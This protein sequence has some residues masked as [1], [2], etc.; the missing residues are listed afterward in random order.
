MSHKRPEA[1]RLAVAWLAVA[2][3][4]QLLP[5]A[6]FRR[7]DSNRD[8]EVD[9]SDPI[10]LLLQLFGGAPGGTCGDASDADDDGKVS[11]T[12]AIRILS[13]LFQEGA[14][15]PPPSE[16]CGDDPTD[17]GL[18]C[19]GPGPCA[20]SP[21]AALSDDFEG[22]ALDPSWTAHNA[23]LVNVTLSG[24]ALELEAPVNS[25]W[26]NDSEGPL[27]FKTVAGDFRVT[28]TVRARRASDPSLPPA[29]NV[30]LG[31][32]M[33]RDPSGDGGGA[34]N[35]VFIVVGNDVN[36][37]SV[38]TKTTLSSVSSYEGPSWP[39]GDAELRVC[40]LGAVVRLYKRL[41][42]AAEWTL[43]ATFT[44]PD[45]PGALQAGPF[46]YAAQGGPDLIVSFDQVTFADAASVAD[47]TDG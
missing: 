36:D 41:V 11:L 20:G 19:E 44:R 8:G 29:H 30:H 7:G 32:L 17:D 38:E 37:L 3:C 22:D 18:G 39:S 13:L 25:L 43:A 1:S 5:G 12:D 45:L 21:I 10:H 26:Y 31:G 15:L 28:A 33:A 46:I 6:S 24:G 23:D 16:I 34:E 9:V 2:L 42:G 47:C 4:G 14:P 27:L 40:R 35:Y